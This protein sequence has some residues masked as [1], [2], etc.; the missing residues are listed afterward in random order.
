MGVGYVGYAGLSGCNACNGCVVC[1][2]C[3]VC[4]GCDGCDGCADCEAH[5]LDSLRSPKAV[6]PGCWLMGTDDF[7]VRGT[8]LYGLFGL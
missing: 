3:A 1:E 4:G 2:D 6:A 7:A 8:R 5:G